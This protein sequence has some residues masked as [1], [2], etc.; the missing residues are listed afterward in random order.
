MTKFFIV[1]SALAGLVGCSTNVPNTQ[2]TADVTERASTPS[3][4]H[5][6]RDTAT[7]TYQQS[8]TIGP[9]PRP[10]PPPAPRRR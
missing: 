1:C 9:E 2:A 7:A 10:E 4:T 6:G 5:M 3:V 8:G